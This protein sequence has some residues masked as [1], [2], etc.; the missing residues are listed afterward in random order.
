ML[1]YCIVL[2]C[3]VLYCIVLYC[4]VLYCIVLYCIVLYCIVLYCIVLY[5]I[6]LQ[7]TPR[8]IEHSV[9]CDFIR[10]VAREVLP[11]LASHMEVKQN[12]QIRKNNAHSANIERNGKSIG[13]QPT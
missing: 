10:Y 4:I 7:E 8:Y 1:L 2:Y 11:E 9:Y 3:I 13:C 6:V 5:C 12:Q